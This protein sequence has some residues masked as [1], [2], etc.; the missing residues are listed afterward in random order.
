MPTESPSP[1]L[2]PGWLAALGD[3]F[4]LPYMKALRVFLAAE[5]AAHPVYPPGKEIFAAFDLA[6]LDRVRVVILGQDPYFGPNQ[7]MG[8]CFSVRRGVPPPPSLQNVYK[9]LQS[10]LGIPPARHGDLT[11]W[12]RQGVLLLNAVLTVRAGEA[13]SHKGQGWERFT[14]R[15]VEILGQQPRGLVFLLWGR[16]AQDKAARINRDHHLVLTAAHPS[17]LAASK[18]YFGCRHFSR[19]NAWLEARGEAPIDWRLPE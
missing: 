4:E 14:D 9:E 13:Y 1:R 16:P 12:A 2:E 18:G 6:P 10:D 7:A 17:P 3:Q 11:T 15:A 8:L 19:A 5:K